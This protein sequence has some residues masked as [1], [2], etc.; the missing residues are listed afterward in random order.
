MTLHD[1]NA[2]EVDGLSAAESLP[3]PA[4]HVGRVHWLYN[5]SGGSQ[6]WT[7]PG[8]PALNLVLPDGEARGVVAGATTWYVQ[9]IAGPTGPTGAAGAA[10]PAGAT[11]AAGP[12]GLTGPAGPAGATGAQGTQ[13]LPGATG[14]TG[15]TGAQGIQGLPGATGATGA[16]G[17]TGLTGPAG[18][19]GATG[20]QGIQGIQGATGATGATGPAGAGLKSFRGTAVTNGGGN[21]TFDLT[22]AGFT[23]LPVVTAELEFPPGSNPIDFRITALS[24][25][26]CTVN[27]RQS[28]TLVVLSLSVLGLA[29]N[30]A[31][32]TVHIHAMPAGAT[33]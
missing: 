22:A 29:A 30:L 27:C 13:G 16:T 21:A 12:T 33:P 23:S 3:D 20:A 17:G 14:A 5:A 26:S 6:T 9:P 2:F 15:A 11:G 24:T 4:L 18:A 8:T 32:V 1:T 31:G 19:T 10:G 28:P 25:T 7:A